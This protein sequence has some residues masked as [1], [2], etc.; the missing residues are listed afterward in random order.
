MPLM[1]NGNKP[2]SRKLTA[3][4]NS[5]F[6]LNS[7]RKASTITAGDV[8]KMDSKGKCQRGEKRVLRVDEEAEQDQVQT[9]A[10]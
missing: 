7:S 2:I 10:G 4:Q 1:A 8:F 6:Q 3:N 5:H 9:S